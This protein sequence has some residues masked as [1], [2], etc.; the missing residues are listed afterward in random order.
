MDWSILGFVD[1]EVY[2]NRSKRQ[3]DI[4]NK[5]A[6]N[7]TALYL[8]QIWMPIIIKDLKELIKEDFEIYIEESDLQTLCFQYPRLYQDSSILQILRIEI[9]TLAE[10]VPSNIML[11][12]SFISESYPNV[13]KSEEISVKTMDIHRTLFEK[14]TIL[15]R[16]CMRINNNYPLRYSRHFYD[17]Y[18]MI[19][20][21][22]ANESLR[23]VKLMKTVVDFKM[24]FYACK[25]AN[26]ETI[27]EGK[28]KL[29]PNKDAIKIFSED[30][31]A[32]KNM[33]YGE[34]PSFE[35]IISV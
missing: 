8:K 23:N 33:I 22:I 30:Y 27:L 3:Q 31:E 4:F 11:L 21:G 29:V 26:Y 18:Q 10:P 9:G 6:N 35:Q 34:Y 24:K 13:F 2:V 32:M 20:K 15:H 28:C 1:E 16:E 14:V 7:N 19:K 5:A 12:N 17:V 25:W